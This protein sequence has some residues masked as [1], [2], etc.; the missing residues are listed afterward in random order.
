MKRTFCYLSILGLTAV[1]PGVASAQLITEAEYY[2]NTDPGQGQATSGVRILLGHDPAV[3]GER[4]RIVSTEEQARRIVS[5]W[6]EVFIR[7]SAGRQDETGDRDDDAP[8]DGPLQRRGQH[9]PGAEEAGTKNQRE[10][11]R[12]A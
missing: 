9:L 6:R 1:C 11:R 2:F 8:R 7:R 5:G 3:V 12:C 10:G 4:Q